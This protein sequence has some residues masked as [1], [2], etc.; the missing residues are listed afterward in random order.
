MSPCTNTWSGSP[1]QRGQRVEIAGVGQRVEVDHAH[2]ARDGLQ[3][4][5]FATDETGA[6]GHFANRSTT[7]RR[8]AFATPPEHLH[9]VCDDVGEVAL[10][11]VIASQF[12]VGDASLDIHLRALLQVLAGDFAE[13]SEEGHAMPLGLFLLVAVLVLADR[14][15]GQADLGDRHAALRVLHFRVVAQVSDQDHLVDAA[16]HVLPRL[17]CRPERTTSIEV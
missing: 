1:V 10:L 14:T 2:A 5:K 6:A 15:G 11:P 8:T 16:G 7:T 4:T 17:D 12:A 13:L 3:S 9:V